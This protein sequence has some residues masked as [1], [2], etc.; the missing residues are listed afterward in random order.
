MA[1]VGEGRDEE[2][3]GTVPDGSA[4][5]VPAVAEPRLEIGDRAGELDLVMG[6]EVKADED[7]DELAGGGMGAGHE[8]LPEESKGDVGD[9]DA[10]QGDRERVLGAR[11]GP[12]GEQ[13]ERGRLEPGG[14][15][16]VSER[17]AVSLIFSGGLPE[18]VQEPSL[19]GEVGVDLPHDQ[20]VEEAGI[21]RVG[22]G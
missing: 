3:V 6:G 11:G 10:A 21:G 1:G 19:P 15:Q 4:S 22:V 5:P 8:V 14:G 16:G 18:G 2:A 17:G 12:R 9:R 7:A 13:R 20:A